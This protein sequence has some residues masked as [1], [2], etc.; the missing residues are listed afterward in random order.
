V[1]RRTPDLPLTLNSFAIPVTTRYVADFLGF[2]HLVNSEKNSKA[3]HSE[4]EIYQH[5]TNCQVFLSYNADETKLLKRRKAFKSSMEFLYNLTLDGNISEASRS[6]ISQQLWGR[7]RDN[8]MTELGF[9]VAQHVLK[10]ERST[11]KAAAILVFVGLHTAYNSVLAVS[12]SLHSRK[13]P[14]QD[15]ANISAPVHVCS[16]PFPERDV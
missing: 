7:K 2:G 12:T 5:I 13:K 1:L 14:K 3:P 10:H 9:Q 4:N 16:E 15:T 6:M 11:T 8:P